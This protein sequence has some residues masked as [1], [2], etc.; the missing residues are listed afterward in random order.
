MAEDFDREVDEWFDRLEGQL[1]P[2]GRVT[3]ADPGDDGPTGTGRPLFSHPSRLA[4][5]EE[6]MPGLRGAPETASTPEFDAEIERADPAR[7]ERQLVHQERESV[8]TESLV[9]VVTELASEIRSVRRDVDQIKAIFARLRRLAQA[10]RRTTAASPAT[11][12]GIHPSG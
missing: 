12:P 4:Q 8:R 5:V 1:A 3:P 7:R 11:G 10:Q 6:G 9:D 2:A